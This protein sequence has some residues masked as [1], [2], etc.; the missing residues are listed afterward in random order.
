LV[1]LFRTWWF[2]LTLAP[3]VLFFVA[4]WVR[5]DAYGLTAERILLLAGGVWAVVLALLFIIRRGDIRLI[6]GLAGAIL[7]LLSVGPWNFSYLAQS[8]QAMRLDALVMNA[9]ADKSA[10]PPRGDWSAE[11]VAEARGIIDYLTGSRE[12][13]RAVREVMG[14]YGVT[15]DSLQDGSYVVLEALG[16]PSAAEPNNDTYLAGSRNLAVPVDVVATPQYLQ[17]VALYGEALTDAGT[18]RLNISA[19][20]LW[21]SRVSPG[22]LDAA[23]TPLSEWL[24][25]QSGTTLTDP[26]ID[27]RF[28]GRAYRLVVDQLDQQ[29]ATGQL[30][31]ITRLEGALFASAVMPTP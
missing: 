24:K 28:E 11:E 4:V 19:D 16:V 7:L 6:P 13:Q 20:T 5:I 21:V 15:W 8:T 10:S 23:S 14:K 26:W 22:R 30:P 18:I 2:W 17:R 3:L 25:K 9:G 12:G 27:F 31:A 29:V 1:R